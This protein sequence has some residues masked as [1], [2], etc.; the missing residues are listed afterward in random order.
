MLN[1]SICT[2]NSIKMKRVQMTFIMVVIVW[3]QK[4][5]MIRKYHLSVTS[6]INGIV[7]RW[8]DKR[9]LSHSMCL[10]QVKMTLYYIHNV[11]D[12]AV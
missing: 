5:S 4:A 9:W 2:V 10:Y 8:P 12:D 3:Y 6:Y 7:A 1:L 11:V